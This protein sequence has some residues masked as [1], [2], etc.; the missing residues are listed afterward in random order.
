MNRSYAFVY[1]FN[2]HLCGETCKVCV[3]KWQERNEDEEKDGQDGG[4]GG[5]SWGRNRNCRFSSK[6]WTGR[7]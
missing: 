3:E 4:E 7:T 2:S 1:R 6:R 5:K